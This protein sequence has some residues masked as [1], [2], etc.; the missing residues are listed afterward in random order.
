MAAICG[1]LRVWCSKQQFTEFLEVGLKHSTWLCSLSGPAACA[2]RVADFFGWR[3]PS[4]S[5]LW[6]IAEKFLL[7]RNWS[8]AFHLTVLGTFNSV[9]WRY[10]LTL[11]GI[12]SNTGPYSSPYSS[13]YMIMWIMWIM[14][15]QSLFSSPGVSFR[16]RHVWAVQGKR[17]LSTAQKNTLRRDTTVTTCHYRCKAVNRD[18]QKWMPTEWQWNDNGATRDTTWYN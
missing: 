8:K 13:P 14:S 2:A 9:I 5:R 17:W 1:L 6:F 10:N 18:V 4:I 12:H 7:H 15:F 16:G 3:V 11:D